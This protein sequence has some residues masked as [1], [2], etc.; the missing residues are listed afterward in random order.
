M[1]LSHPSGGN[2]KNNYINYVTDFVVVNR[3]P[4]T[5]G[6]NLVY[7][8]IGIGLATPDQPLSLISY[9]DIVLLAAFLAVML[10]KMQASVADAIH[11]YTV[12]KANPEKAVIATAVE[13]FSIE[14]LYT[15]LICEV[16]GALVLWGW[17]TVQTDSI[18]FLLIG[19]ASS[20]LG[21][22]YSYPPRL[23]ERGILNH[24]VTTGVDVA[25][26]ILPVALIVGTPHQR[27]LIVPL[28]IVFLYGFGYH[29]VHQAADTVYDSESGV[30]TFT[31]QIGITTSV[32]LASE[33]TALAAVLAAGQAYFFGAIGLAAGSLGYAMLAIRIRT[34]SP[35]VQCRQISR[36]F[37][38][39][40][41]AFILNGLF[42]ASLL[43]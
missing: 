13:T 18:I 3:L 37:R 33:L 16:T 23:K 36:W 43:V 38:I 14:V 25:G 31:Q 20:V 26:V 28:A 2:G 9:H 42:A 11:D 21:F 4:E 15:L 7:F 34:E 40:V 41:W 5:T 29:L 19:A 35:A 39:G 17:L 32:W 6:Y 22:I 1:G 10:S 24:L 30:S 27:N 8:A 12:D